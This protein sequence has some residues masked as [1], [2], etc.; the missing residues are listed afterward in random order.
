MALDRI[1]VVHHGLVDRHAHY[2]GEALGWIEACGA[3]G[4][5]LR[6]YINRDA[7]SEIVSA[8]GARPVFP[9]ASDARVET[10]PRCQQ[11]SDFLE[12]GAVFSRACGALEEDG[13]G[14]DDL[15]VVPFASERDVFGAALWL[16]RC[17]PRRVRWLPSHS[18]CR[19]SVGR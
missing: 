15:V 11:L 14:A 10:D 16:E 5:A 1:F 18:C 12:L 8:L 9:Y 2:F 6:L 4:I 3:R 13:V 17:R 19:T 7:S